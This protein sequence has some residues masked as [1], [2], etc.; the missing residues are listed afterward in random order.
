MPWKMNVKYSIKM[1]GTTD[2]PEEYSVTGFSGLNF[3]LCICVFVCVCVCV[4][5]CLYLYVLLWIVEALQSV[6]QS[7]LLTKI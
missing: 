6:H 1:Q 7:L 5:V 3:S 4:C 2:A